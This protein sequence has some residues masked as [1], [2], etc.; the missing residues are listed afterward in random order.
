MSSDRQNTD[1]NIQGFEEIPAEKNGTFDLITSNIP[2][3]NMVVY[4]QMCIRDRLKNG[5]EYDN[6]YFS[7]KA[8]SQAD[9]LVGINASRALSIAAKKGG[10]SLGR[11]QTPLSLIH[12]LYNCLKKRHFFLLY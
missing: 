10:Y 6:L 9:W 12:I 7:G 11:V 2:F 1:I 4:D 8:R 5:S 3:G